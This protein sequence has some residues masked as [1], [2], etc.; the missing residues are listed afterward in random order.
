[1]Y[2]SK[3]FQYF[4]LLSLLLALPK[5]AFS[6]DEKP[7]DITVKVQSRWGGLTALGPDTLADLAENVAPSV[8]NIDVSPY[9]QYGRQPL[10]QSDKFYRYYGVEPP[11]QSP[12]RTTGSGVI[13]K[14]DGII[15]TSNHVI[16]RSDRIKVTLHDGRTFLAR[17][18][19]SDPF[20]DLAVLKIEATNLP[21]I[22]FGTA[23]TVRPGDWVLAIGS[24]L[25]LDHTVTLGIV[26]ALGREAKGLDSFGA[27]SGAVRFIQTD[28]AINPG[29]SGGPLVNL[30]GEV[31]GLNT[32]IRGDAQNIGFAIPSDIVA[33]VANTLMR[34]QPIPHPF[35]GIVMEERDD[36]ELVSDG[37]KV[38]QGVEVRTVSPNSPAAKAG[39][40]P[41]D[42]ITEIEEKQV[43]RPGEVSEIVRKA[44]IGDY[45]S[46]IIKRQGQLRTITVKVEQLPSGSEYQ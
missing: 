21:T 45:L 32:F 24:P 15:M 46:L 10:K 34:Q 38:N 1:M 30:K 5:A 22:R 19:G 6:N 23:K 13:L 28:A 9:G 35:I 27:R 25:G 41:G 44:D 39:L 7:A 40:M 12:A 11:A 20:S 31:V 43:A 14:P 18:L 37:R 8:V 36:N 16:E 29:N 4:V 42:I 17:V 3:Y 26:S 2:K 33:E